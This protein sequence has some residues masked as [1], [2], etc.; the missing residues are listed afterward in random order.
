MRYL[1]AAIVGLYFL[2]LAVP[3]AAHVPSFPS[4]N[5]S[6]ATALEVPDPVKSWS[7]HDRIAPGQ[8]KYYQVTFEAGERL[9][10]EVF[11]PVQD[12]FTPSVVL[13]SRSIDGRGTVPSTVT[14]PA[15]MGAEVIE[16]ERPESASYEMFAPSANYQTVSLD[17]PVDRPT[18]YLIAIYE[19]SGAEGPVGVAIGFREAFSPSEYLMVSYNLVSVHLWE[20]QHPLL[21]IGPLLLT[22]LGGVIWARRTLSGRDRLVLRWGLVTAGLLVLGTAAG[23]LVQTVIAVSWTGPTP[24]I[25]VTAAFVIVPAVAGGWVLRIA[26]RDDLERSIPVRAGL[27]VAGLT[28]LVTWAGY[29]VGPAIL[30][31]VAAVPIRLWPE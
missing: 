19:P 8:T 28:S 14:V 29:I 13:M 24:G 12:D 30:I 1:R 16:G 2:L 9:R 26:R 27:V 5:T 10:L 25:A 22:F 11:T 18:R 6:P 4:D 15:G 31:L 17:R 3:A 23:T 7:F 20:G 21:V